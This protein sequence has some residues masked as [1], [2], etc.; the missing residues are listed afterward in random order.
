MGKVFVGIIAEHSMD[1]KIRPL[2]L[3]WADGRTFEIDKVIDVRQA[4]SLKGGG[5]GMRYTCWI[6]N[7]EVYLFC[8]EGQWFIEK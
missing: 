5:Q 2:T 6:R 3:K 4:A 7:K 1:G 8:D